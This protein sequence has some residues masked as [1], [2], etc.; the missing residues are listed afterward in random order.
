MQSTAASPTADSFWAIV[1]RCAR[2]WLANW[3]F[4]LATAEFAAAQTANKHRTRG[5]PDEVVVMTGAPVAAP[6]NCTPTPVKRVRSNV[7]GHPPA[8][9]GE[10]R[11]ST[12]GAARGWA[13]PLLTDKRSERKAWLR[14]NQ[15]QSKQCNQ[16]NHKCRT[17]APGRWRCLMPPA[18]TKKHQTN[19]GG[20][21]VQRGHGK[22]S[23]ELVPKRVGGLRDP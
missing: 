12:W 17:N 15:R 6:R 20:K 21:C 14:R 9:A 22:T 18:P 1:L 8:E 23:T 3:S 5:K 16:G 4:V 10:G 19:H 7:W 2:T 11:R 13:A